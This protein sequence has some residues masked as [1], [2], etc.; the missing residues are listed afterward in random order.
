MEPTKKVYNS[1]KSYVLGFLLWGLFVGIFIVTQIY[2][3]TYFTTLVSVILLFIAVFW[4]GTRYVIQG[5]F[6]IIKIGPFNYTKIDVKTIKSID[7]AKGNLM[8]APANSFNR[9]NIKYGKLKEILLSP[10][11]REQFFEDLQKI[12]P[13]LKNGNYLK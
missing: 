11:S 1:E 10:K 12:N 7:N 8:S 13:S 3:N 2:G 6:L 4:F 9:I 5:D